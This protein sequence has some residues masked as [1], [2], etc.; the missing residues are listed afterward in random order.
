LAP[1]RAEGFARSR[2]N[3]RIIHGVTIP[4]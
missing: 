4:R 1:G 3:R 2:G